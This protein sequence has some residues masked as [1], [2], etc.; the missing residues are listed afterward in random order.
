MGIDTSYEAYAA[1]KRD[2]GMAFA[3]EVARS[4][5]VE[6]ENVVLTAGASEAIFAVYSVF[7]NRRR[8]VVPLPNHPPMFTVPQ[9]LGAE[10]GT[11]VRRS[12]RTIIG[13][14][15]P[16][17]PTG[18]SLDAGVIETLFDSSRKTGATIFINETY[19]EFTSSGEPLTH[20]GGAP[21]VVTCNTMTKFYGLGRLR[22]GWILAGRKQARQLLYAKWAISGND[23]EYSLWI[24]TQVLRRRRK[25]VE[26]SRRIHSKNIKL[27]RRFLKDTDQVTAELGAAPFCLVHYSSGPS[28]VQLAKVILSRT[29]VLVGPGDFFGAPKAFRLCFTTDEEKLKQGLEALSD[30]FGR[31]YNGP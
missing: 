24:A 5:K 1:E 19:R 25:F 31:H 15:D 11:S 21:D 7:G 22:V 3:G 2:L 14:T 26:R 27:V 29:G 10:V 20:F 28:S 16:N 17:N 8:A 13:L 30:F 9:S 4:Y 12:G 6:P 18:Q 23:S